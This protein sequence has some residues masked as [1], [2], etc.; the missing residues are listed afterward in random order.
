MGFAL[1][2]AVLGTNVPSPLYGVYAE[3]WSF[4]AGMVT[5][6]FVVYCLVLI[7]ALL[8]F[9]HLSDEVGRRPVMLAGLLVIALGSLL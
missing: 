1:G 7:G 6:I 8:V 2:L 9:G 4:S 3:E 5:L